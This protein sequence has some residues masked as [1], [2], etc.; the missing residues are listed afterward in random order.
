[1]SGIRNN[2]MR[3]STGEMGGSL[4]AYVDTLSDNEKGNLNPSNPKHA[5]LLNSLATAIQA[6]QLDET[7][8]QKLMRR[9]PNA[10]P[11]FAAAYDSYR[12]NPQFQRQELLGQYF[13][14]A[15]QELQYPGGGEL[16]GPPVQRNIPAKSDI[17]G[18]ITAALSRGDVKLAQ[19][20]GFNSPSQN[21]SDYFQFLPTT[22]GYAVGDTRKGTITLPQNKVVPAQFD[23]ALQGRIAGSRKT[24]EITAEVEGDTNIKK[25]AKA[26]TVLSILDEADKEISKATGSLAGAATDAV[27]GAFGG[28]TPGAESIS[29]LKVLQAQ[30]MT[31]QPRMEGPQSDRDVQLYREMAGQIGD[32]TVPTA[33]KKRAVQTIRRINE[34]YANKQP[35]E[36]NNKNRKAIEEAALRALRGR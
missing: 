18:A 24:G 23:P 6:G 29:G 35:T 32:P 1:M 16:E 22:E 14:P 15:K 2:S 21:R 20:L 34:R 30:L 7:R 28:T 3:D 26:K 5:V 13:Q 25:P 12:S 9:N 33:L 19:E 8:V 27:V 10:A 17:Q 4:A 36:T 31:S 11:V